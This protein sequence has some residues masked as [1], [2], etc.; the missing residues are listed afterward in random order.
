MKLLLL[1]IGVTVTY[2]LN[3][4]PEMI[5][6]WDK[7]IEPHRQ[8]CVEESN[9]DANEA[10]NFMKADTIPQDKSFK[11]YL[12]CLMLQLGL[13]DDAGKINAEE[14]KKLDPEADAGADECLKIGSDPDICESAFK[15]TACTLHNLA[16]KR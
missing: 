16:S 5:E 1:L 10:K 13:M 15:Y 14:I 6:K 3:V 11:C 12:K 9:V 2:S 4:K 8:K 7:I